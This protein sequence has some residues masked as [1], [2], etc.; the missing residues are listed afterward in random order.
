[1]RQE[2]TVHRFHWVLDLFPVQLDFFQT[3]ADKIASFV[4]QEN[5]HTCFCLKIIIVRLISGPQQIALTV[6]QV[7]LVNRMA[8]PFLADLDFT[9]MEVNSSAYHARKANIHQRLQFLAQIVLLEVFALEATAGRRHAL[10]VCSVQEAQLSVLIA[11][12]D[13]FP[14]NNPVL[15]RFAQLALVVYHIN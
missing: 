5:I 9:H 11:T 12:T 14:L 6:L 13:G 7:I 2:C 10:K 15:V 1:V 8:N 4:L 3:L